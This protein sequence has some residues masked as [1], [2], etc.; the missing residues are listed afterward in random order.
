MSDPAELYETDFFRWTQE[1]A[2]LLRQVP[3][4]RINLP[5][6]WRNTADEI[7][8]MGR[9]DLR[10]IHSRLRLI[11][12]HLLK[13]EHSPAAD[14]RAGWIDTIG[15]HRNEVEEILDD[16][17]SLRGKLTESWPR[18]Y[19]RARG[20]AVKGLARDGVR[21]EEVS[22]EPAYTIDQALDPDWWPTNRH[23]HTS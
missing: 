20:V 6:D 22:L 14:P 9:R 12:E 16:S 5:I 7:E 23:G 19:A 8:D 4:E 21:A 17:P 11:L 2:A 15:Q 10:S 3:G 13:L 18:D 1:Q